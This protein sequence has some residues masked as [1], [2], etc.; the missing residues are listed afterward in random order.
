[1]LVRSEEL[2]TRNV[3]LHCYAMLLSLLSKSFAQQN[4]LQLL[5]PHSYFLTQDQE[6]PCVS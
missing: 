1:M 3:G 4:I 6:P 5:T 2:G